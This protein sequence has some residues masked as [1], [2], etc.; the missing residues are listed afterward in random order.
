M[1][2]RFEMYSVRPEVPEAIVHEME[3]AFLRCGRYIP[4]LLHCA[5]G[6]NLSSAPIDVVWEHAYES[7]AAYQRYMVHRYHANILDRYLL[8]D[9]PEN[10]IMRNELGDAGLVGYVCDEPVYL[11]TGGVRRLVLLGVKRDAPAETV[12]RLEDELRAAPSHA[13]QL[14]LSVVGANTMGSA[15]FDGVTPI[16]PPSTWTHCWEQGFATVADLDAYRDGDSPLAEVERSAWDGFM[17]GIVERAVDVY[18]RIR[19]GD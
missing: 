5:V 15:W 18:Y 13:S 16:T 19:P 6:S 10:I 8:G 9:C 17:G 14:T 12:R 3:D 11:M 2:R 1:L 7:P 4:E